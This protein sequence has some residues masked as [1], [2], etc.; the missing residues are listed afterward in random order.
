MPTNNTAWVLS[1]PPLHL[2]KERRK[3]FNL[4]QMWKSLTAPSVIFLDGTVFREPIVC[5]NIPRL[6]PNWTAP[7]CIGRHAFLVISTALPIL[8]PRAKASS[9]LLLQDGGTPQQFEV[10]NFKGDGVALTMYNTDE[11]IR[12]C[13][14]L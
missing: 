7:I 8:L 9:P 1:A 6:V 3:E 14:E 12:N 11:S 2:T 13:H 10:F 4:K 5:K